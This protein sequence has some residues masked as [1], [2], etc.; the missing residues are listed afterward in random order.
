LP[1]RSYLL[2]FFFYL[3]RS[4][5]SPSLLW[6]PLARLPSARSPLSRRLSPRVQHHSGRLP[7]LKPEARPLKLQSLSVKL[8]RLQS[9]SVACCCQGGSRCGSGWQEASW[10]LPRFMQDSFVRLRGGIA[11]NMCS[12]VADLTITGHAIIIW[13]IGLPDYGIFVLDIVTEYYNEQVAV[14]PASYLRVYTLASI[15]SLCPCMA[16]GRPRTVESLY[17]DSTDSRISL[18]G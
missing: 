9:I 17:T 4:S 3:T 11:N 1:R 18:C 2:V 10:A 14:V 12:V 15:S 8:Q 16:G 6:F 7:V 13:S 5:S